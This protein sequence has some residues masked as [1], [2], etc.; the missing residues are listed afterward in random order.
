MHVRFTDEAEVDLD[1]L[2]DFL[3]PLS[4]QGYERILSAILTAAAQLV[5]FPFIGRQGRVE[6]TRELVV[7][8]TPYMLVYWLP[9][10]YH[11]DVLRVFHTS[12]KYPPEG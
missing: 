7:P 8:R 10:E 2:H 4:P 1:Q 12:M 5:S 11:V 3:L 9:D 6:D